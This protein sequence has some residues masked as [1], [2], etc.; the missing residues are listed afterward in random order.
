MAWDKIAPGIWTGQPRLRSG[1]EDW[2][3]IVKRA[4]YSDGRQRYRRVGPDRELAVRLATDLAVQ[5]LAAGSDTLSLT[6]VLSVFDR[7][8]VPTLRRRTRRLYT[9]LI[10][11][12]IIPLIG[13][14]MVR[15][16]R[17]SDF[18]EFGKAMLEG[19]S[20]ERRPKRLALMKNCMTVLRSALNWY[21]SEHE[22]DSAC[23]ARLISHQTEKV[24]RSME[25]DVPEKT[26]LHTVGSGCSTRD[27]IA[28]TTCGSR[29]VHVGWWNGA[30]ARRDSWS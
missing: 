30:S 20:P 11:N 16:L 8:H 29:S 4:D 10:F 7:N 27:C 24:R 21:W 17:G 1:C 22:L 23:P 26:S 12:H 19:V 2:Y 9:G 25:I 15:S 5:L 14:K 13:S 6:D 3:I 28:K 18:F